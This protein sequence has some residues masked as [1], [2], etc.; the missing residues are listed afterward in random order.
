M[1]KKK[2]PITRTVKGRERII[3]EIRELMENN[4]SQNFLISSF[5]TKTIEALSEEIQKKQKTMVKRNDKKYFQTQYE[6]NEP[7]TKLI[8]HP[9]PPKGKPFVCCYKIVLEYLEL[10]NMKNTLSAINEEMK[11]SFQLTNEKI[12]FHQIP[13]YKKLMK[14]TPQFFFNNILSNRKIIPVDSSSTS[15]VSSS[16]SSDVQNYL[17]EDRG[18]FPDRNYFP[19]FDAF[20]G[21]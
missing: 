7:L 12:K 3:Y 17:S 1:K 13:K 4:G 20:S 10:N 18:Y 19:L 16:T 6:E 8:S 14:G 11:T 9:I 21:I 5:L 15:S 2:A